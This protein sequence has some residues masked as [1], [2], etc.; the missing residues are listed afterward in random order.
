MPI[1]R[2]KLTEVRPDLAPHLEKSLESVPHVQSVTIEVGNACVLVEHDGANRD[3]IAA[4]LREEGFD[5][6]FE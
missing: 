1:Y 2:I 3:E 6:K 4:A 5:P